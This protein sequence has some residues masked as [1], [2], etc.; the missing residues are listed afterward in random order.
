MIFYV[1]RV[2]RQGDYIESMAQKGIVEEVHL[3]HSTL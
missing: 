2:V 1:F 3:F